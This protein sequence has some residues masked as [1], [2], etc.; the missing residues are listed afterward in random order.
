MNDELR[1]KLSEDLKRSGFYSEM[2]VVQMCVLRNWECH[3]SF[4]YYDRDEKGTR[5][6]DFQAITGAADVRQGK[7]LIK[8]FV[9]LL[10]QVKK[11]ERPWIVFKDRTFR[12][13]DT[14]EAWNN[15][16]MP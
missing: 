2:R 1:A 11:A 8:L 7:G 10:G 12:T 13:G 3:G 4:T 14:F 5:E 16:F 6:C 9:R 15:T